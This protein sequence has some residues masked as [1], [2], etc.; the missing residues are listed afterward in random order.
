MALWLAAQFKWT[1]R[2]LDVKNVF[3]HGILQEEVYMAQPP[4]FE[5]TSHP[6]NYVS[7]ADPSLFVHQSTKGTVLL[8]LYV[9]DVI[10]TGSSSHMITQVITA[11]TAEFEMKDL[12][13]LHYF[14]G[15]QI[16]YTSDGLFVSQ[17]KY[18]HELVDKVDL[19]DSKPCATPCLPYHRLLKDDGQPYH[20]PDQYRSVVGALQY[21]TFTRP[22]ISF[23]VNQACQFMHNPMV[24]H[25]IAVKRIIRSTSGF[26]VFLGSNPISWASKK[27]HT[28]SRSSTE[29][30]YRALAI[31]AAEL[32][33]IRQLLCDIHVPRVTRGDL[34]VQHVSSSDQYADILTKGL[35][36]PLFQRHC[37][38]LMLSALEHQLEGGCKKDEVQKCDPSEE[39]ING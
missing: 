1:L 20:R 31:T 15:L 9:D 23:S 28:I 35:S 11:L 33:W 12:G 2:Q 38:N 22:D 8:L 6:S 24:S 18:I 21:L 10:I 36:A 3:L 5:S 4:G 29:A 16:S 37:S 27:Q 19:Q 32:A 7:S 26:V 30:E 34:Q 39:A 13:L 25:V 17:T 14:L